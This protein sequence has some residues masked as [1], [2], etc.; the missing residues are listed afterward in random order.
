MNETEALEIVA[1]MTANCIAAFTV[2]ITL[3]FAYLTAA[4]F[5]GSKLSLFQVLVATGMYIVAAGS[6]VL[7]LYGSLEGYEVAIRQVPSLAPLP[8]I[9]N[10]VFWKLYMMP[11]MMAGLLVSLAFMWDVRRPTRD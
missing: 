3:A 9:L 10:P 2:Y 8:P 4:Y 5:V 11:V 7:A 6:C 1:A